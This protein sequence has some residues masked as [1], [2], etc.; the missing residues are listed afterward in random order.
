MII[1]SPNTE[2]IKVGAF[3]RIN[4]ILNEFDKN[5]FNSGDSDLEKLIKKQIHDPN[6]II[7]SVISRELYKLN[8][9]NLEDQNINI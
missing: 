5:V 1:S 3:S 6:F 2:S 8:K 7:K 9:L 4:K